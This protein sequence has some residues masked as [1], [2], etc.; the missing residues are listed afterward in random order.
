[1]K[2]S[3]YRFEFRGL[4]DPPEYEVFDAGPFTKEEADAFGRGTTIER[5][6]RAGKPRVGRWYAV[7]PAWTRHLAVAAFLVA[8]VAIACALVHF[9]GVQQ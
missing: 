9:L 5:T 6:L 1:M 4:A 7:A 2:R 8:V 3:K